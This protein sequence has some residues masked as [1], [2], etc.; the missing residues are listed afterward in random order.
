MG[1]SINSFRIFSEPKRSAFGF[2]FLL[3]D[4]IESS[5]FA[6]DP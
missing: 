5:Q 6:I 4:L 3:L 1:G 2:S